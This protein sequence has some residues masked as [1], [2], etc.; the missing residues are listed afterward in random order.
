MQRWWAPV[1]T[2]RALRRRAAGRY[3]AIT[4]QLYWAAWQARRDALSLCRLAAFRRDLGYPVPRRWVLDLR[5]GL[6]DLPPRWRRRALGMLAEAAPASLH[7]LPADW[8]R[9]GRVIPGVAA[10]VGQ[11]RAGG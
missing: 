3:D 6:V 9:D 10:L 1:M 5:I 11:T 4:M 2:A 7:G 8:L